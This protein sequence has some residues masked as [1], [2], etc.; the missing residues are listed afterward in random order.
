MGDSMLAKI[1]AMVHSDKAMDPVFKEMFNEF[2][3]K[4]P[5]RSINIDNGTQCITMVGSMSIVNICLGSDFGKLIIRK[6]AYALKDA[7]KFEI[8]GKDTYVFRILNVIND[9]LAKHG[10]SIAD[11]EDLDIDMYD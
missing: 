8:H 4:L 9:V 1:Y 3:E 10:Y 7:L 5:S 6:T 11:D 2:K